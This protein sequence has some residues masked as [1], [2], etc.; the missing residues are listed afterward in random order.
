MLSSIRVNDSCKHEHEL[1]ETELISSIVAVYV[2]HDHYLLNICF[3]KMLYIWVTCGF[4]AVAELL[5]LT[6]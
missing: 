3:L 5:P 2:N 4:S 6:S 1:S